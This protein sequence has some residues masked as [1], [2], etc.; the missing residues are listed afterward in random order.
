MKKLAILLALAIPLAAAQ[1]QSNNT[2]NAVFVDKSPGRAA[3]VFTIRNGDPDQ[4]A[5]ALRTAGANTSVDRRLRMIVVSADSSL[6]NDLADIV[7]KMDVPAPLPKSVEITAYLIQASSQAADSGAIPADLDPVIKQ[8]RSMFGYQGYKLLDSAMLRS[9]ETDRVRLAGV[10]ALPTSTNPVEANR[11]RYDIVY[12]PSVVGDR[13]IRLEGFNLSGQL[14]N[15]MQTD[16]EFAQG[17][18]VVVGKAG[19]EGGDRNL[20]VVLSGRIVQ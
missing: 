10:L 1:G 11:N 20:I 7:Q 4:I 14:V 2:P 17:Q 19:L 3:R 15:T 6:L 8:F 16:L 5:Q 9:R 13:I 12:R 18:K